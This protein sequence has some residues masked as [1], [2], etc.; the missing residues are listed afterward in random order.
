MK[1]YNHKSIEK[2]WQGIWH[3]KK[4]FNAKDDPKLPKY[5]S[6]VEFPYPSGDGLHVGHPRPYIG[7]DVIS[8]KRRMEGKNVLFPIGWDAFGLPTENYAIKTGIHPA[9]VTKKNSDNFR[10][11]I[12]SLGISFDWSR[13][14][15]TTDPNYYKWTQWIFLQFLK[16]GLAYKKKM[17][18]NW[19]P[20]DKIG[21][22]NEEVVDGKCERCG[23]AVEKRD[24]EQWMLAITKYADRLDKDLDNVDYLEKIKLQQRNWI[25]R[26]EG[27]NITYPIDGLNET[28]TVFT[29]RPDTNYGAT[30]IVLAP[31]NRLVEK[32]T[33][34]Q[35]KERVREYVTVSRNKSEE[36]RIAEGRKKTGIFTGRYAIN[37]LT[38]KKMPIWVS[39]FVIGSFGTGAVVGVPGHDL[40]DFQFAKEFGLEIIRVVVGKDGDTSVIVRD[41]QVQESEGVMVNSGILDGMEIH[42]ATQKIMDYIAEKGWGKRVVTYHIRDWVFSRQHYWGE[43]IPV[44]FCDECKNRKY[45]IVIIHGYGSSSKETWKP[46]LKAELEKR[47]HKVFCPD[48]PNTDKP[49]VKEQADFVLKN[50]PFKLDKNTVIIGHS[51]GGAVLMRVLEKNNSK[52]YKSILLDSVLKPKFN[53]KERSGVAE[54]DNWQ[55]DFTK[56]KSKANEFVVLADENYP[57]IPKEDSLE[58]ARVFN[59]K[60]IWRSPTKPHF[61]GDSEPEILQIFEDEGVVPVPENK[62]PVKLPDVEKYQPT[63]SGESPLADI[64]K[65]VN[66]RC[67]RCGGKARRETD[68]MPNWAGSSWYYLAYVLGVEKSEIKDKKYWDEKKLNYWSGLPLDAKR[69]TLNAFSGPVDWYNGGMEHTTLHL[70]YSR[71]WHKFLFD[72]GVVPTLEPYKKR[73]SHGL[74]LAEGGVK[75]SKS[76]GNVINPDEMVERFGAD[77]LRTYEMFMGP[78]EQAIAWST[79]GLVGV[80]RF[81]EKVWRISQKIKDKR[82]KVKDEDKLDAKR[83]TLNAP[84]EILIH[85]TV[86]KVG[87]DVEAMRFNTAVSALMI[88]SNEMDSAESVPQNLFEMYLKVLSLFAPHMSEE[89][90]FMLGHKNSIMTEAWPKFDETKLIDAKVKIMVQVNGKIRGEFEADR[91]IKDDEATALAK[92]VPSVISWIEN[93][94]IKKVIVVKGRLINFVV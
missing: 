82:E 92:G 5:Y 1:E 19:C 64:S 26:K 55:F 85:K 3:K 72:I 30:F 79:D 43:P 61:R 24:K 17:A 37:H 94:Q 54:A 20:K 52:I 62:L 33:A 4:L 87:E 32:I 56:I 14:I 34:D 83:F 44:V 47:G 75:M 50:C 71:F 70:L 67:P 89:L 25:G 78:F 18:I 23:T 46:W 36:E 42:D 8:R 63:D 22:A 68:T 76:R 51:L 60:L 81:L 53:D 73:T 41:E 39:D 49:N 93:K 40:R 88:A 29:T 58:L 91:E 31:E 48:L 2:K 10:R 16:N 11:Q 21:L 27:I 59:A 57:T 38:G 13:E 15:N 7:M 65:W 90:W 45:D 35:Y 86:K 9:I 6:L 74:I 66:T 28:V 84:L 69:S 77:T 12:K 80:K